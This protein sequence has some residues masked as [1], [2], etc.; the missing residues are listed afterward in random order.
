MSVSAKEALTLVC[1]TLR[2]LGVSDVTPELLRRCK[3]PATC[4]EKDVSSMWQILYEI[5]LLRKCSRLQFASDNTDFLRT[6]AAL[7]PTTTGMMSAGD[8]AS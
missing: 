2:S 5:L 8:L 3:Y 1:K 7:R 6:A 4:T